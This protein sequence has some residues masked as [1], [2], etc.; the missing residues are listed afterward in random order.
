MACERSCLR[1]C[2]RWFL[3]GWQRGEFL[4][5][6]LERPLSRSNDRF[7]SSLLLCIVAIA[8]AERWTNLIVRL[9]LPIAG[10]EEEEEDIHLQAFWRKWRRRTLWKP[11]GRFSLV[12]CRKVRLN[13]HRASSESRREPDR[14]R[15][16]TLVCRPSKQQAPA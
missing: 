4:F 11:A 7:H 1:G 2:Q 8:A 10:E 14:R 13:N 6:T 5:Q 9:Q 12:G 3:S 15:A 16:V